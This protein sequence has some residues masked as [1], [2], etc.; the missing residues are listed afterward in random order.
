MLIKMLRTQKTVIGLLI[1]GQAYNLDTN[2]YDQAKVCDRLLDHKPPLAEKTTAKALEKAKAEAEEIK[3]VTPAAPGPVVK[4]EA[5][6]IGE[7]VIAGQA[8]AK[9]VAAIKV[10]IEAEKDPGKRKKLEANLKAAQADHDAAEAEFGAI[11]SK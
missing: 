5:E 10:K 3:H 4:S 11:V 1:A 9:K 8:A 7:L 2:D 6:I